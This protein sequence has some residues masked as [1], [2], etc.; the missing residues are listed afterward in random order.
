MELGPIFRALVKNRTRFVL[1]VLEVGLALA[2]VVNCVHQLSEIRATVTKPSG[3]ADEENLLRV[4]VQPFDP[5]LRDRDRAESLRQADVRRL[6]NLPGVVAVTRT[7]AVP[8]SGSGNSSGIRLPEKRDADPIPGPNFEVSEDWLRTFGVELVRGRDFL[9]E[10]YASESVAEAILTE[11]L[12]RRLFPEGD[13]LGRQFVVFG[14]EPVTVVGLV[15]HMTNA[16]PDSEVADL[17]FFYPGRPVYER[18]S[19]YLVRVTP[20]LAG[21]VRQAIDKA[22]L[23]EHSG[24]TVEVQSMTEV[25]AETFRQSQFVARLLSAVIVLLV[26]VTALGIAGVTS[27]SVT[28]RTRQIGTRRALGA[29]RG[30]ILRYFLVENALVTALGLVVGIALAFGLNDGLAR[31]AS[32]TRLP[33][34]LVFGGTVFFAVLG[35]ATTLV[36][37]LRATKVP[38]VVATRAV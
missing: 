28:Q 21:E 29:T 35:Q 8:L 34:G 32:A 15:A 25:R 17:A 36:P 4:L 10:D 13:P 31:F 1:I 37:A 9:P 27:F 24:R 12:A 38:P 20:G 3:L 33:L 23:A 16:W 11:A 2:V 5:E 22:L 14:S 7:S 6:Q 26:F 30:E 18:Y 19:F